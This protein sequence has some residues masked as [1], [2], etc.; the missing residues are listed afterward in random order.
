MAHLFLTSCSDPALP[1]ASDKLAGLREALARRGHTLDTDA[2][3]GLAAS[4]PTPW[5]WHPS[6]RAALL[7]QAFRSPEV[8]AILDISGG[9]L[10]N[11]VLPHLDMDTIAAHPKLMVGY[12]DMSCILGALPQRTLLWNPLIGLSTGFSAL[13][14]ALEGRVIRPPLANADVAA[15]PWFGGNIRCFLKLAGTPFWPDL[16]GGALLLEGRAPGLKAVAAFLAHHALLGTFARVK[17]VVVGQF[18]AIDEA[19][20]REE[21]LDLIREYAGAVPLV[22]AP[23][24]GHSSTSGAVTLG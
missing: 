18:T 2:L 21:L 11:E 22:E 10:A 8:D 14:A 20:E 19:R 12:S 6:E 1:R 24:I 4:Q 16:S 17:A 5:R 3:E 13:D 15:L 9:D 23:T 7:A